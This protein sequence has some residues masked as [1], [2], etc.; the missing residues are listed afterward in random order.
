M[1]DVDKLAAGTFGTLLVSCVIL[2][3]TGV[4]AWSWWWVASPLLIPVALIGIV[5]LVT[6][7][8]A[9]VVGVKEGVATVKTKGEGYD[10]RESTKKQSTIGIVSNSG[11]DRISDT[12]CTNGMH[13]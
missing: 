12:G 1:T 5:L 3:L 2:K 7:L 4:V 13:G 8:V 9:V 6:V 10:R 11:D